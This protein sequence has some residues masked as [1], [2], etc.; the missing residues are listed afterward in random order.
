MDILQLAREH[1]NQPAPEEYRPTENAQV[2]FNYTFAAPAPVYRFNNAKKA[3]KVYEDA[4]KAWRLRTSW[5]RCGPFDKSS[6]VPPSIFEIEADMF[7]GAVDL[8]HVAS[9]NFVEWPKR[10][11]FLPRP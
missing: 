3:R 5:D 2:V 4:V 7:D 8:R 10:G 6:R 11:K 1:M 9:I